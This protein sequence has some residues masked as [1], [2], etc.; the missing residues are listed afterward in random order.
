MKMDRTWVEISLNALEHN[1]GVV[2]SLIG[3]GR[4]IIAV[5]KADAY[6]HGA[7]QVAKKLVA[8]G[9]DV[10]GVAN[11]EEGVEVRR[12]GLSVPILL[13][14]AALPEEMRDGIEADLSFTLSNF[15]EWMALEFWGTSLK[16]KVRA[17]VKFDTGMGRL[18]FF[19]KDLDAV[20][21]KVRKGGAVMVE[22]YYSHFAGADENREG[23]LMQGKLAKEIFARLPQRP[24][25]L[26]NSAG[27]LG[28]PEFYGDGVRP[29]LM[30]YGVS[31][32]KE[33]TELLKPVLSWKS[34]VSLVR[35]MKAGSTI[36]YGGTY[37]L[38]ED[39]W[40]AVVSLGYADGFSRRLSNRGEVLIH[41]DRCKVCGRVTM[42]EI[43]VDVTSLM[44]KGKGVYVGDE[45]VVIGRC[46]DQILDVSLVAEQAESIPWEILTGIG[47]RV[48]RVYID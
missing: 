39:A 24:W 1:V 5:V 42:D 13:L 32:F 7:V 41:G 35:R 10:L 17:H 21:T 12:A 4:K 37:R 28:Y 11:V 2:R 44:D 18:G 34:R 19:P 38:A 3:N 20:A 40:I 43:M 31:P 22:E 47:Q 14:G 27:V 26:A 46:G 30:I 16:K 9:V 45:V 15:D 23:T 6:G 25:H 36:S 48:K 8:C 29:G 33:Q